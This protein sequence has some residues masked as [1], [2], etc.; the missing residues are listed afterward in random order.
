L[1]CSPAEHLLEPADVLFEAGL[2]TRPTAIETVGLVGSHLGSMHDLREQAIA[3]LLQEMAY[4]VDYSLV[5]GAVYLDEIHQDMCRDFI[6]QGVYVQERWSTPAPA[7]Q[8]VR[9]SGI[10]LLYRTARHLLLASGDPTIDIVLP[11]RSSK[12]ARPLGDDEEALARVW[13]LPTVTTTRLPAA[14]ALGQ[15]TA[16]GSE[17]AAAVIDDVDLDGMRVWL[18]GNEHSRTPRWG[19]LTEWGAQHLR[20]R[21]DELP[22]DPGT[23]LIS[24]AT[25]SRNARQASSCI[26]VQQ[27]MQSAGLRSDPGIRPASLPAWAGRKVF[28]ETRRIE[29]AALAL[30]VRSL[31]S[32]AEIIGWDWQ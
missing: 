22:K 16:T 10:R 4:F 9:R 27:V 7:T 20:A 23:P 5:R 24:G 1:R 30:G 29:D 6:E 28:E 31:D 2:M 19:R 18:H 14:W 8:Y 15:A 13:C 21:L 17:M 11:P 25:A 12:R 3:R 32:A 26:A